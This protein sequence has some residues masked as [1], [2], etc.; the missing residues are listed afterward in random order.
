MAI[1]VKCEHSL[2]KKKVGLVNWVRETI[3]FSTVA[4]AKKPP[5]L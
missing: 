3:Y 1:F 2:Y 5:D 4:G